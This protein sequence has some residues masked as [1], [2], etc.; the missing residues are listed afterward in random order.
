MRA[1]PRLA[2]GLLVPA[3]AA[4]ALTA[5]GPVP[6][7][8]PAVQDT[9]VGNI[10][11]EIASTPDAAG[12]FAKT[13]ALIS[14]STNMSNA[15]QAEALYVAGHAYY[16]DGEYADATA[17]FQSLAAL[18][19]GTLLE[20][21]ARRMMAQIHLGNEDFTS[22]TGELE[23]A[24]TTLDSLSGIPDVEMY[25]SLKTVLPALSRAYTYTGRYADAIAACD[26]IVSELDPRLG[27]GEIENAL[28]RAARS[29]ARLENNALA[30]SYYDQYLSDPSAGVDNA[31]RVFIEV[32]AR[33]AKGLWGHCN[34]DEA[35][36]MSDLISDP[37]YFGTPQR[38][39]LASYLVDCLDRLGHA[40]EVES[41]LLALI[42]EAEDDV[43]ALSGDPDL[44]G[45]RAQMK[46][47]AEGM[48]KYVYAFHLRV[49][50]RTAEARPIFQALANDPAYD[51]YQAL[52]SQELAQ[53]PVE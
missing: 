43:E 29:A 32:D 24:L 22:A 1:R 34:A 14:L 37:A 11:D 45:R 6:S 40:G 17:A 51:A 4:L 30:A 52:A 27:K 2:A 36:F 10:A 42:E 19:P 3:V 39:G 12:R 47:E 28:L 48:T 13:N 8:D 31:A 49:Q 25:L 46:A 26:R 53:L 7:S 41:L 50:G 5:A 23:A 15:D 18:V 44:A 38:Y 35:Q 20:A 21:E 16:A 9:A 33:K